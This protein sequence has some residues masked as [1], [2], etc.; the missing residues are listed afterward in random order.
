MRYRLWLSDESRFDILDAFVWY[1]T[2]RDGLGKDF[3][4][5]LEAAFFS[6]T[7][8]PRTCQVVYK[9]IR[10]FYISRFP[11][12][13]HYLVEKENIR[14]LGVFHTSRNPNSWEERLK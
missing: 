4:L 10:I 8:N 3:E 13:I 5:C 12:G 11:Y 14:I 2:Q 7:R 9:K 6:L 1:E